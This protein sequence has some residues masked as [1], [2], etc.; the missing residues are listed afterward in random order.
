MTYEFRELTSK[1]F[2]LLIRLVKKI[3]LNNFNKVLDKDNLKQIVN[4]S[5]SEENNENMFMQVGL[6]IMLEVAQ[7]VIESLDKCET[8]VY[9]ILEATSNLKKKELYSMPMGDFMCMVIE[10]VKKEDFQKAFTQVMSLLK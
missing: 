5:K 4:A 9:D 3:G 2:F 7:I 1:D 8:E 6:S 10:F